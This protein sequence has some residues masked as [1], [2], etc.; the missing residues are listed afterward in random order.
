VGQ[1]TEILQ[2]DWLKHS[3][4]FIWLVTILLLIVALLLK[5]TMWLND[6]RGLFLVGNWHWGGYKMLLHPTNNMEPKSKFCNIKLKW[7]NTQTTGAN[8][9]NWKYTVFGNYW[10]TA[11]LADI[12]YNLCSAWFVEVWCLC[13]KTEILVRICKAISYQRC[14]KLWHSDK[15]DIELLAHVYSQHLEFAV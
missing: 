7:N 13:R 11:L 4:P 12:L 5:K 14:A 10:N 8:T 6:L 9:D 15:L 1:Y 2:H 3:F